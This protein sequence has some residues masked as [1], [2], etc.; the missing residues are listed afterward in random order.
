VRVASKKV[1]ETEIYF[2]VRKGMRKN[3]RMFFSEHE[4]VSSDTKGGNC[5]DTG[6]GDRNGAQNETNEA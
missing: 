1:R 3:L 2:K 5:G 6:T 4:N